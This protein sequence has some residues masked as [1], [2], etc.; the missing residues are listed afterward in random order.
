MV[1]TCVARWILG[2]IGPNS[3]YFLHSYFK[4]NLLLFPT[5]DISSLSVPR[6]PVTFTKK[7]EYRVKN[8]AVVTHLSTS[9]VAFS[10]S[11]PLCL[12]LSL[13]FPLALSF[14]FFGLNLSSLV[15]QGPSLVLFIYSYFYFL[16]TYLFL[17]GNNGNI[18]NI[19]WYIDS[20]KCIFF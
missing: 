18:V 7:K 20:F 10:L 15:L 17:M 3:S 13:D 2:V 5:K 4:E 16:L 8:E 11:L 14:F 12:C 19:F 1:I 6:K 9:Q